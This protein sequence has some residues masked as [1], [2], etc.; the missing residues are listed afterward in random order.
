MG[1]TNTFQTYWVLDLTGKT[2]LA[3][4]PQP[5]QSDPETSESEDEY[6]LDDNMSVQVPIPKTL[7]PDPEPSISELP[8]SEGQELDTPIPEKRKRKKKD[9]VYWDE[10]VGTREKSTRERKPGILAVGSDPDHPTDEQARSSPQAHE[11][12]KARA[13]E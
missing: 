7:I 12:A 4:N 1:Y 5:I 6:I 13:A 8:T 3:K 11:W 2:K 9:T 10:T